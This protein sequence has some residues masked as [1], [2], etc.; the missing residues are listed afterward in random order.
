MTWTS[1]RTWVS[2]EIV[3]AAIMNAHV[4]DQFAAIGDPWTAYT[5]SWTASTTNPTLGNGTLVGRYMQ[6]GKYVTFSIVLTMGSTTTFGTGTYALSLP[7]TAGG[8][9]GGRFLMTGT[10]RDDSASSDFALTGII[11][12]TTSSVSLRSMPTT[13]GNALAIVTQ[14]VPT[15]WASGD[16]ITISGTYEAA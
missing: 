7:F 8:A 11:A 2:G 14:A 16:I 1:P 5:P 3:T 12:A 6:A 13:A 10:G 4:R 9:T 15:T